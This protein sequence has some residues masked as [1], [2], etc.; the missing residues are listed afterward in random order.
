M[1]LI[2]SLTPDNTEEIKPGLFVQNRKGNYRVVN[3]IAW[4]GK[5][6]LDK[7]FGWKNLI[8]IVIVIFVAY[9]YINE[10]TFCRQLQANPCEMLPEI[11]S[12]CFEQDQIKFLGTNDAVPPNCYNERGENLCALQGDP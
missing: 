3:P 4:K 5:W 1:S 9:T 11:T 2:N 12:Y 10:T 6:R 7:Q 8:T